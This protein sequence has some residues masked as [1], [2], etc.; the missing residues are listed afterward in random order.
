MRSGTAIITDIVRP[1]VNGLEMCGRRSGSFLTSRSSPYPL[2]VMVRLQRDDVL[3]DHRTS[4][5]MLM[6]RKGELCHWMKLLSKKIPCS[7]L[8]FLSYAS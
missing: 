5:T 2:R 8:G 3:D 6:L 7:G 1:E 4:Y